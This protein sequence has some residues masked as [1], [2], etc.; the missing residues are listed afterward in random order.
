M[1]MT[2]Q[3]VVGANPQMAPSQALIY[4]DPQ[5]Q[6]ATVAPQSQ[7]MAAAPLPSPAVAPQTATVASQALA[8]GM[9][10]AVVVSTGSLGANL[11]QVQQ[12]EMTVEAAVRDSLVKGAQGGLAAASA[13]AAATLLTSGGFAGVAVTLMTATGVSY[14]LSK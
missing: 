5:H 13:T 12:G 9:A 1:D 8:A 4:N 6:Y 7:Y 2:T 14:L 10:G 3:S 11:R